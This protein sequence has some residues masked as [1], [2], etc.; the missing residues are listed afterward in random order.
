MEER[1]NN[2]MLMKEQNAEM[3]VLKK[4]LSQN[5]DGMIGEQRGNSFTDTIY[6]K[7]LERL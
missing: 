3:S 5:E 4:S 6:K 2:Q 7:D 1:K